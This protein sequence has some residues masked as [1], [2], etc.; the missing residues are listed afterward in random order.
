[1][2]EA[3]LY[4]QVSPYIDEDDSLQRLCEAVKLSDDNLIQSNYRICEMIE[5][6]RALK[7]E[8]QGVLKTN[9]EFKDKLPFLLVINT[10]GEEDTGNFKK[11]DTLWDELSPLLD[12][13]G[14]VFIV[15]AQCWGSQFAKS[16]VES[17][18]KKIPKSWAVI[19]L[20]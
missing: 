20:S 11:S 17:N 4:F 12:S 18:K 7:E 3:P 16:F 19:G 13:W 2:R 6:R 15:F 10:H 14:C 5:T 8:L 1:M 9:T